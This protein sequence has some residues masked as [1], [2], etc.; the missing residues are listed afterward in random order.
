MKAVQSSQSSVQDIATHLLV[1]SQPCQCGNQIF[2][3]RSL[4]PESAVS[5]S[6]GGSTKTSLLGIPARRRMLTAVT[7][8]GLL[9]VQKGKNPVQFL[10]DNSQASQQH[11]HQQC[12]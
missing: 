5:P 6:E 7:L 1:P 10:F 3:L 8:G 12:D 9:G 11:I 4:P 2:L